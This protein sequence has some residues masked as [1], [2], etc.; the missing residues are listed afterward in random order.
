MQAIVVHS[1]DPGATALV[2]L[3]LTQKPSGH[4]SVVQELLSSLQGEVSEQGRPPPA[5]PVLVVAVVV[6]PPCPVAPSSWK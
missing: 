1:V 4:S 2:N 6:V 3:V 5:P